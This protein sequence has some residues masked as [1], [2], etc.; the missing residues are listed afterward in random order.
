MANLDEGQHGRVCGGGKAGSRT[1][2][3]SRQGGRGG[4]FFGP[5]A[6]SLLASVGARIFFSLPFY[7]AD[8]SLRS[9]RE[10]LSWPVQRL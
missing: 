9:S 6:S 7:R 4:F 3:S 2:A 1:C 10:A 5:Y 8:G